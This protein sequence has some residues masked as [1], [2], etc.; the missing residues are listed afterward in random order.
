[1]NP[2]ADIDFAEKMLCVLQKLPQDRGIKSNIDSI[3]IMLESNNLNTLK[4]L[5]IDYFH[6]RR[7]RDVA[8]DG[9]TNE[10]WIVFCDQSHSY[11]FSK[12]ND[13]KRYQFPLSLVFKLISLICSLSKIP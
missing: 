7:I 13:I 3:K 10:E 4:E 5:E 2:K 1:M 6:P 12:R 9:L 11:I 8:P